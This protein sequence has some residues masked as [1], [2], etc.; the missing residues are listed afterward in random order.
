MESLKTPHE[1]KE[2]WKNMIH[3]EEVD[4]S[5]YENQS[6]NAGRVSGHRI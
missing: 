2:S 6:A 3:K 4:K 5:V 1:L